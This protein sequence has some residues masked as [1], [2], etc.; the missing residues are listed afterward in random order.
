MRIAVA[1][2]KGG[3][4]KTIVATNLV[5]ALVL[6]GYTV[7]YADCDVEAP[8]GHIFLRPRITEH[9][10]VTIPVPEVDEGRC[11]RCGR[12][13]EFCQFSAIVCLGNSVLTFPELCHGCG[14]CA[15]VCPE[16]AIREVPREIGEVEA[17][18]AGRLTVVQ[19]RLRI[20]EAVAT[21]L[22]RAVK[23]KLPP[24]GIAVLDAPPGTA[25]P[26]VET[27]RGADF[28]LL[29]TEPTPFG[30]HD[31]RL[32]VETVRQLGLP[33]GVVVNR[34][35]A[36]RDGVRRFCGEADLPILLEI[37]DERRIAVAYSRG[38]LAVDAVPAYREWMEVLFE[39][40]R[41][42]ATV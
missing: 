23:R 16:Q 6:R 10:T 28:V 17:G 3:T 25:C 29:V 39:G 4:G 5:Q 30:L 20:G 15:L 13:G 11:T 14:G 1:S 34:A 41:R 37:P 36:G 42:E 31:L 24:E 32:A 40:I 38:D 19:G 18:R 33:M 8:N 26:V 21:P 7:T 27:V 22:I 2:G 9:Q 12:C 35:A